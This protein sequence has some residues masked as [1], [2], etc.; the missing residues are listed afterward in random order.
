MKEFTFILLLSILTK[1]LIGND[2]LKRVEVNMNFIQP[3]NRINVIC[4]DEFIKHKSIPIT[5]NF[6]K[7]NENKA[8]YRFIGLTN[9]SPSLKLFEVKQTFNKNEEV[10]LQFKTNIIFD[11][12]IHFDIKIEKNN[13][14]ISNI[15]AK[16]IKCTK[17]VS[18]EEINRLD[19]LHIIKDSTNN[20]IHFEHGGTI[21]TI[22]IYTIDKEILY[23][24]VYYLNEEIDID[25]GNYIDGSYLLRY[26][27]DYIIK[28]I[29]MIIKS[30]W[31]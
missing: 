29:P 3:N 13:V 2:T 20:T 8:N 21:T 23:F 12:R 1:I 19:S 11:H 9:S 27:S 28:E 6:G 22:S 24:K 16:I 5:I 18:I 10:E 30:G 25:I 17:C 4:V 14:E 15:K 7:S 26:S 31:K